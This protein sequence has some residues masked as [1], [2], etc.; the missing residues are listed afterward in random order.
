MATIEKCL[1]KDGNHISCKHGSS[2]DYP[3]GTV[4][5]VKIGDANCMECPCFGGFD[6]SQRGTTYG[7]IICHYPKFNPKYEYEQ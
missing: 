2:V 5:H 7:A 3:V 1:S 4:H 6:K